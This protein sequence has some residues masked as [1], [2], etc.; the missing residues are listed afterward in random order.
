ML[1]A[2]VIG[3]VVVAGLVIFGR[4]NEVFA[5]SVRKG[6]VLLVRGAIPPALLDAFEDVARRAHVSRATI[7]AVRTETH[8]R[9]VMSGVDE[10]VAQRLRNVFG[11][12]HW[13]TL[14]SQAPRPRVR[15]VGQVLGVAWLAWMFTRRD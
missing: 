12:H 4:M 8:A 2:I 1:Y 11:T 3:A 5:V 6:R 14:R 13:S 15:N 9:L 7:R 10:G